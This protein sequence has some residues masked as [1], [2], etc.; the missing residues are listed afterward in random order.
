MKYDP[1]TLQRML[2]ALALLREETGNAELPPYPLALFLAVAMRH[3]TDVAMGELSELTGIEHKASVSR[4]LA[5]LTGSGAVNRRENYKGQPKIAY[6]LLETHFDPHHKTRKLC[7]LSAAGVVLARRV[8]DTLEGRQRTN[9]P[10]KK[11]HVPKI[12]TSE[13]LQT[14][15]V[16]KPPTSQISQRPKN[17]SETSP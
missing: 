14:A 2:D 7:R 9:G 6:P 1:T 13:N 8:I 10:A 16:R 15:D 11:V 17:T 12:Y 5:W 3:P 4:N